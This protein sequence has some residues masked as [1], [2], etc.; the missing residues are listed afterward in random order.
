MRK[1]AGKWQMYD[2]LFDNAYTG[3]SWAGIKDREALLIFKNME[4]RAEHGA[5]AHVVKYFFANEIN[6]DIFAGVSTEFQAP[7]HFIGNDQTGFAK[8]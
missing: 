8:F 7:D 4:N 6:N 3:D 5:S 1:F 2:L